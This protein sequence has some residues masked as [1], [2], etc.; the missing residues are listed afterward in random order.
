MKIMLKGLMVL[1]GLTSSMVSADFLGEEDDTYIG[2]QITTSLDSI[3]RGLFSGHSQYSYLLIQKRD[4]IKDGLALTQDNYGNQVLSYMRPSSD[5]DIGQSRVVEYAV[6]I[7]RL[8]TQDTPDTDT[9]S[10]VSSAVTIAVVG[11]LVA[12]AVSYK[13]KSDL[14]KDWE[15]DD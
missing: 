1:F 7:M 6:P 12:L 10:N 8:E 4:G 9:G 5:F 3:S 14:E 2:F 13:A 11:G 15:T